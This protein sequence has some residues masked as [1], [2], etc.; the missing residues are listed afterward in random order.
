MPDLKKSAKVCFAIVILFLFAGSLLFTFQDRAFDYDVLIKNG[1]IYDGSGKP[2]FKADIAIKGDRV[3]KI[4]KSLPGVGRRII[5]AQGLVV[6][7]GFI[8]LHSHADEGMYFPE[9][10]ACY[11]YLRQGVTTV[12]VGQCGSSA[13]PIFEKAENIIKTWSEEGIGPNVAP[14]VGHG[15]VRQ[16][17]MGMEDR[18]PTP[19]E[20]DKMKVLVKEAMEQG[21]CGLS[22]GLIYRPGSF[23]KTDELVELVK[24][25][26]PYGGIY[27]SHIRNEADRHLEAVKEAIEIAEKTGVRTHISHFKVVGR[28]NWGRAKNALALIEEARSRGLRITADQYPY[29]FANNYPYRSLIPAAVWYGSD[30]P[31]RLLLEDFEKTLEYL[32]DAELIELYK[33]ATPYFPLSESHQ[34]FL[35]ELPRKRLVSFVAENIINFEI[36]RGPENLRERALFWQRLADPEEGKK[37][38]DQLRKYYSETISPEQIIIGICNE[39]NLEGKSLKEAAAI[40]KKPV[41]DVAIELELMGAKCVPMQMSPADIEEIMKKDYMATGSDGTAS[42]YGIGLP[43]IRSYSTFIHKIKRYAMERKAVSLAHVIR[44]QTSLPAE[45]MNWADRGLIRE[46]LK[47][48]IV[49]LDLNELRTPTSISN[50]HQYSGGVRYLLING[51]MTVERGQYTGKLPGQV[52]KL[53]S[54]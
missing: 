27:H 24:V 5:D 18:S 1:N 48:D 15:T 22:T 37:I 23:S 39:K 46:G 34:R 11:N 54:D 31:P 17:V 50:P 8:D 51:V 19:E 21:A 20:L 52:L 40:K 10:R 35:N 6:S 41:E 44:S 13:W 42:F 28:A 32:R 47:A 9:N 12:V 53:K 16:I 29:E 36:S 25:I 7:P 45:I 26:A 4:G 14:L 2:S 49:I 43:H 30:S 33:K 3:V 38:R